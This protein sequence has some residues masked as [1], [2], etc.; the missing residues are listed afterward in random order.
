MTKQRALGMGLQALI[1]SAATPTEHTTPRT[2]DT[3]A[4]RLDQIDVN[5][6]QPRSEFDDEALQDLTASIRLLGVI[7]PV[8][9]CRQADGR[10]RL[11]SG[12]R[13][14]RASRMAGLE[15]IPAYIRPD[16]DN[17]QML[18]MALEENLQREDLDAIE[19]A[20]AYRRLMDEFGYTQEELGTTVRK[21]RSTVANFLRLLK[22]PPEIQFALRQKA[23]TTGHAKVLVNIQDPAVQLQLLDE[24]IRKDLSVR[25]TEERAARIRDAAGK[26]AAAVVP[27][28]AWMQE[29]QH[30]LSGR[31]RTRVTVKCNAAGDAGRIVIAF[32][33]K[34]ALQDII[35]QLQQ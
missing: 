13:R 30:F 26:A 7:Q 18:L 3:E 21:K 12:E 23:I 22:L 15:T 17:R 25:A 14:Y 31:L 9:V 35:S 29:A 19:I 4:L 20:L 33:S 8:T 1:H 16:S 27:A 34:E 6:Y 28:A 11:I 2:A 24:I 5:P 10:Y 32:D